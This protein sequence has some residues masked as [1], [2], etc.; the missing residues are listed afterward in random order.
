[1]IITRRQFTSTLVAASGL[2]GAGSLAALRLAAP[3]AAQTA[4][5][6]QSF[7]IGLELYSLRRELAADVPGTLAR[8]KTMGFREVEVP[9]YYG[10][11][12][13]D[14]RK[15]LDIAGLKATALVAQWDALEKGVG[16]L[17]ND[18]AVL[19]AT[20]A[21]LPWIPHGDIFE[22]ADAQSAAIRM[23]AWGAEI[24]NAGFRFAYHPHGYEF[25]P[26]SQGTLFDVLASETD[27]S[28]VCFEMDTFWIAWP[29]QDCVRLL[30]EYPHRFRLLHLK[31]LKKGAG[32]GNLSGSAP[33]EDSVAVGDGVIP[34]N[35]VLSV[36][37]RQG[38]EKYYIEDESPSAAEQIPRS[39][40]Y[41]S[42][43]HF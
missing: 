8:I 36:A 20:W 23:N 37:R 43:L 34:W 40:E 30:N 11:S 39:L 32:P 15:A 13:S 28:T 2:A 27:S 26:A 16:A 1:M 3:Q 5:P 18:L 41:L 9:G 19:G 6:E 33:D 14:F 22:L 4:A 7:E 31:D 29:G 38:C 35:Q 17:A 21:I 25:Q 42:Q 24:H 10:L 12:V